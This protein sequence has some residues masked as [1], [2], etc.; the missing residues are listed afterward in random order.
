MFVIEK[1]KI[2]TIEITD[3]TAEGSGVGHIDGFAVFVPGTVSGDRVL[4]LIV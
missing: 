3:V 2:Y 1:N 4:V